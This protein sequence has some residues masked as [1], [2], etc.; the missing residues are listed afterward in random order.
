MGIRSCR[1]HAARLPYDDDDDDSRSAQVVRIACGGAASLAQHQFT[2]IR[3]GNGSSGACPASPRL[4]SHQA[5]TL[6]ATSQPP[7]GRQITQRGA[8]PMRP[9]PPTHTHTTV[10]TVPRG[11]GRATQLAA[12]PIAPPFP[13]TTHTRIHTHTH[14]PPSAPLRT[15]PSAPCCS[16]WPP[17]R[18][19]SSAPACRAA[20]T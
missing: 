13:H 18:A 17:G 1:V 12:R 10:L 15:R 7:C 16:P 19:G 20:R 8:F 2:N 3:G 11:G 5:W 14:E 4:A 6:Q 9:P